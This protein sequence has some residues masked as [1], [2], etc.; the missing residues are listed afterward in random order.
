MSGATRAECDSASM[1]TPSLS[2]DHD[3]SMMAD[4]T[5]AT[6]QLSDTKDAYYNG[7]V[8]E[9][10]DLDAEGDKASVGADSGEEEEVEAFV[11]KLLTYEPV[12]GKKRATPMSVCLLL[13]SSLSK[14][15]Q[16]DHA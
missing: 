5:I 15:D 7:G 12:N 1:P 13:V 9:T 3:D 14:A 11:P 6:I 2:P 10:T 8:F 4:T 16:T